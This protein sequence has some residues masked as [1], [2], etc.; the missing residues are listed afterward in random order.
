M[1]RIS[2]AFNPIDVHVGKRIRLRR[3]LLGMSQTVLGDALGIS[4]QQLQKCEKGANRV[5]SSRLLELSQVLDVPI[6]FFFDDM[7]PEISDRPGYDVTDLDGFD[8]QD[9][10]ELVSAFSKISNQNI[11]QSI[12]NLAKS[13]AKSASGSGKRQPSD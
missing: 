8:T 13:L 5:G 1:G 3:I 4:F 11:K 2:D 9:A 7:P 6:S 10:K 12:R